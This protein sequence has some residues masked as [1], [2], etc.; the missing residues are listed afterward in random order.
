MFGL[1]FQVF[2]Q[3]TRWFTLEERGILRGRVSISTGTKSCPRMITTG[4]GLRV[5]GAVPV[6]VVE[7]PGGRASPEVEPSTDGAF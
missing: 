4:G 3:L 6:G 7:W 2:D 1:A 5:N